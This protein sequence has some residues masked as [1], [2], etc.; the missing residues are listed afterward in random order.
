MQ[1]PSYRQWLLHACGTME[2][3]TYWLFCSAMDLSFTGELKDVLHPGEEVELSSDILLA[4]EDPLIQR[5]GK[6][7][8]GSIQLLNTIKNISDLA[9]ISTHSLLHDNADATEAVAVAAPQLSYTEQVTAIIN[10]LQD[11][12]IQMQHAIWELGAYNETYAM[13]NI[14]DVTTSNIYLEGDDM[15]ISLMSEFVKGV[16]ELKADLQNR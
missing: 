1:H 8:E 3:I 13:A 12:S 15:N 7:V 11:A 4:M 14:T 9:D 16:E 2:E 10:Y 5:M 6:T